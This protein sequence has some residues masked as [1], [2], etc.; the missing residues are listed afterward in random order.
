MNDRRHV[1]IRSFGMVL[2][3]STVVMTSGFKI[4]SSEE[5]TKIRNEGSAPEVDTSSLFHDDIA[6]WA[7]SSSREADE[8]L[9]A[10]DKQGFS[11]AC[12]EYGVQK[13]QAFPCTF[14]VKV[15]GTVAAVDTSSRVGKIKLSSGDKNVE[16]LIGPV[17]PDT[18]LRDGY[19]EIDYSDFGNQ[20]AFAN[21]SEALNREAISL[22]D[23]VEEITP[24]DRVSAVGAFSTWGGVEDTLQIVPVELN[25]VNAE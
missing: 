18:A 16:I 6:P 20:D 10:I 9:S 5:L 7:I 25:R 14:W 1:I 2:L 11:E 3:M 24:G 4:V 13:S 23:E 12:Q 15:A 8:I 17:I 22:V 19:P 21:L